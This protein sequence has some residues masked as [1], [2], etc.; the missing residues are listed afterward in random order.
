MISPP[1]LIAAVEGHI[2]ALFVKEGHVL[3]LKKEREIDVAG[4]NGQDDHY[5]ILPQMVAGAIPLCT[6]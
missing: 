2:P 6:C 1:E 4:V 5:L 3:G